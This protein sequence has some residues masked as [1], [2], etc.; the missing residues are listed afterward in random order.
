M[1]DIRLLH[2]GDPCPCCGQPIKTRKPETLYLLSWISHYRRMPTTHAEIDYVLG[3][4]EKRLKGGG[5]E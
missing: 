5:A 1:A 2:T 4:M 3:E